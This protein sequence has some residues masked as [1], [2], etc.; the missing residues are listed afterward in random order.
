MFVK[1]INKEILLRYFSGNCTSDSRREVEHWAAKNRENQQMFDEYLQIWNLSKPYPLY[2]EPMLDEA[3]EELNRRIYYAE[4]FVPISNHKNSLT[5]RRLGLIFVRVAAVLFIAFGLLYFLHQ[6][7]QQ[8]PIKHFA[9]METQKAPVILPDKSK[10]TLNSQSEL[11]YPLRFSSLVRK[12]NFEGEALFE[13]AHNPK[14]PFV[15]FAGNVRVKVLGTVFDLRN[16]PDENDITVYLKSGKVLFYS[17][18]QNNEIKEQIILHPGEM[19]VYDKTTQLITR[20]KFDNDNYMAWEN[21]NLEFVKAPLSD[22]FQTLEKTFKLKIITEVPCNNYYLTARYFNE[23]PQS[24]FEALH[25]I[26]GLHYKIS[27]NKVRVF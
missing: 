18:N 27:G 9:T 16:L 24:I 21:G 7:P 14:K 6:S 10:V 25:V 8:V 11:A 4:Q 1:K 17:V 26:Y 22:V 2:H 12:V 20:K 15:V 5:N 23:S 13:V 3:W 19:G